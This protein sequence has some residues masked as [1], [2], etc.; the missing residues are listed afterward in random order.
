MKKISRT[1]MEGFTQ[2]DNIHIDFKPV[3]N[4]TFYCLQ[5]K[6]LNATE[7]RTV[8]SFGEEAGDVDWEGVR[9]AFLGDWSFSCLLYDCLYF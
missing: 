8:V 1:F 3:Q 6:W 2:N 5:A 9:G 4:D 7:V